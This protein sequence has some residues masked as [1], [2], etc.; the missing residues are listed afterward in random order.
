M[1][2]LE[3]V[4][5]SQFYGSYK[6]GNSFVNSRDIPCGGGS[7]TST[8][9]LRVVGD[10]KKGSLI[11]VWLILVVLLDARFTLVSCLAYSCGFA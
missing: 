2:D 7:S 6:N 8:V 9:T 3:A 4:I 10:D 11:S 5:S 1:E